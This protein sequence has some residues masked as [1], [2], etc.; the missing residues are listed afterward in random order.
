MLILVVFGVKNL[1]LPLG[2]VV[3]DRRYLHWSFAVVLIVLNVLCVCVRYLTSR[4]L[5]YLLRT[6]LTEPGILMKDPT[7][8]EETVPQATASDDFVLL[9]G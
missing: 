1:M 5:F 9:S 3:N 2:S 4:S 8:E 7:S 6:W